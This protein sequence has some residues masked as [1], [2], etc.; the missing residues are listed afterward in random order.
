MRSQAHGQVRFG[1]DFIA[2]QVGQRH[3]RGGDQIQRGVF[4]FTLLAAL[5]GGK[6]VFFKLGQL[7]RAAQ[8][9]G[10]DDVGHIA[11]GVAVLLGLQ[12]QHELRQRAV[13]AGQRAFHDGE[14]RAG[15]LGAG[16]KVQPQRLA[17][18][19][20]VFGGK[21][22]GSGHAAKTLRRR[23]FAH[24]DIAGFTGAF[25]H[26]FV[27]QIGNRQQQ[28]LQLGLD[29]IESGRHA[30]KLCLGRAD[31]GHHGAGVFAFGF[32][33]ADLLGQVV[34]LVLQLFGA[35]LAGLAFSFERLKSLDVQKRLRALTGF[36]AGDGRGQVFAEEVDVKHAGILR[37]WPPCFSGRIRAGGCRRLPASVRCSCAN[38]WAAGT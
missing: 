22:H 10:V 36:Q 30:F 31:L 9:V 28:R 33:L 2:H 29:L 11:F 8:R 5:F 15:E 34:A 38:P 20:M 7:P 35:H 32:E 19:H 26:A 16:F 21:G 12:V 4:G 1:D 25:G 23:P 17:H 3:F 24:F 18:I 37:A 14:A 6:Q 27:R 13:H